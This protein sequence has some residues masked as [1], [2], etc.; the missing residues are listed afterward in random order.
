M[1]QTLLQSTVTRRLTVLALLLA[2][3]LVVV[4]AFVLL[5]PLLL[6]LPFDAVAL[7]GALCASVHFSLS[8]PP[9]GSAMGVDP[10][11]ASEQ[12]ILVV[13]AIGVQLNAP[14]AENG[15]ARVVVV[16]PVSVTG[17]PDTQVM[18]PLAAMIGALMG[19]VV[20][21]VVMT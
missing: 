8:L 13:P 7:L 11:G 2:A 19:V 14:L 5:L 3:E 4:L 6:L 21:V 10:D 1:A 20:V 15:S 18:G 16:P 9:L 17:L 12:T